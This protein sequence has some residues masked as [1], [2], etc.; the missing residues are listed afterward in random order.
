DTTVVIRVDETR[1]RGEGGLCEAVATSAMPV[2][3][4]IGAILADAFVKVV[5]S[6]GVDIT[7]V[8]H[9]GRHVP[10]VLRTAIYERD[11]YTC[12][13][14]GA[15]SPLMSS[16]RAANSMPTWWRSRRCGDRMAGRASPG[17]W[18]TPSATRLP[19]CGRRA[20]SSRRNARSS[21]APVSRSVTATGVR[22]SSR[23]SHVD[24]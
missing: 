23:E 15:G 18:R 22:R 5:L 17:R 7:K 21:A 20:P 4:A 19:R 3:E 14:P 9:H 10:E 16:A 8:A 2:S 6:E 12:V 11:G 24:R 13:R 1:L